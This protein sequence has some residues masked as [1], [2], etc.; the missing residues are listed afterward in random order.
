MCLS[1]PL[2]GPCSDLQVSGGPHM[3]SGPAVPCEYDEWAHHFR[4][5][6]QPSRTHW[7]RQRRT[8]LHQ[9]VQEGVDQG[10]VGVFVCR[11]HHCKLA[12]VNGLPQ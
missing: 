9:L 6:H 5:P 7:M 4:V 11:G 10:R 12:Q 8:Y 3:G 2:S 1:A